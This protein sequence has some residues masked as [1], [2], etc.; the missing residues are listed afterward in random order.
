MRISSGRQVEGSAAISPAG[1]SIIYALTVFLGAF[2]LFQV[3]PLI[4]KYI[5]PW[6]GG[7]PEV[8]STLMLFFQALLLGGYAYAH[9]IAT[10]LGR[11]VQA[12]VHIVF[13]IAALAALPITPRAG[14]KPESLDY[15]VLRILLLAGACIGLP[16]FVLS[17]TGPL[18]QRWFSRTRP[19]ASPY[20]LY[21]FSNA[22][23]LLALVSYPFIVE[24]AMSR[25]A[26]ARVWSAGLV[27]FAVLSA[28]C[29][30]RLWRQPVSEG[31]GTAGEEDSEPEAVVTPLG[32][33]LLWLALPAGASVELLAVTN[34]ICQDVAVIPFLWVLPLSL[35]LLSFIICFQGERWY[36]RPVFLVGFILAIGGAAAAWVYEEDLSVRQ[37]ILIYLALLLACCM[38]CHGELFRLRPHPRY[39]TGY[40]LMIAAGGALGG[41]FVAVICPVIFKTYR[42][43]NIGI[44]VCCLFV[45]L[46][47]K[48][49]ALGR[50]LRRW[51]WVGI[52]LV[53]G[54][55]AIS[56]PARR[57]DTYE[58]AV[59]NWR[60]FFGVL[61][62][63]EEDSE[64]PELHRY[65]LQHGTTCHG[66]QFVEPAKRSLATAYYGRSSGAGLAMR[67]FPRQEKRRIGV[68]GLG[69]GTLATYGREGDYIRFY[70]IN[71][72][73]KR[74]AETHFT[75]LAD[76]RAR[77]DV[78]VG[79]ARLSME[80]EPAQQF[81]LLLLDAFNGDAVPVHL[82]TKEAFEI[83]LNH[84]KPDGVIAVHVSQTYL[85]LECVVWK[86]ADHFELG[87]A[88]IEDTD[89]DEIGV[90]SSDWILLTDNEEFLQRQPI[91]E[92][93][94]E[95]ESDFD[96]M[97][98]WTDDYANLFQILR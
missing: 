70:E 22:G 37:Q 14:W 59:L 58:T 75:Y 34:K 28:Y 68:V 42:E 21:A 55:A 18:M 90:L 24:P 72:E 74:L 53:A 5:L 11:R 4:G 98:L 17:S 29:A 19:G 88:W 56:A 60:N 36:V 12:G 7:G 45:L 86:L 95:P 82:L 83:Y 30:V 92:A 91:Q 1:T 46:A 47:D 32:T 16:Y 73:V 94:S 39:L 97:R 62:I 25:A 20:R 6:F 81:D 54:V 31:T 66:L 40:Y 69:V 43:L 26:Q 23:S 85:R 49:T 48:S 65:V 80:N 67:F 79:D 35:Y 76:C 64:D 33:R 2:L 78:I 44:L 41:V 84:M 38:V 96:R 77:V 50:G 89:D 9:L 93:A 63:W 87:N 10:R 51:F 3:Q 15:P 27:V 13:V 52:I 71:P 57:G 61:T 8:W